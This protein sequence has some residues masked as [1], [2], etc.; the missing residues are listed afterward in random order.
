MTADDVLAGTTIPYHADT[1]NPASPPCA[2]VGTSGISGE[3]ALSAMASALTLPD[4]MKGSDA[5]VEVNSMLT[6][7]AMRSVSAG[8]VPL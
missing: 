4:L 7:P 5:T 8:G 6:C 1:S 2:I 3:R